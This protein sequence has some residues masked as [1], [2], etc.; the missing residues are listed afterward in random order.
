M[1]DDTVMLRERTKHR[2][3]RF[4]VR[5]EPHE[6]RQLWK[7][8]IAACKLL[9]SAPLQADQDAAAGEQKEGVWY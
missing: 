8:D 7:L 3:E 9:S 2:I 1:R 5:C 4:A 6:R